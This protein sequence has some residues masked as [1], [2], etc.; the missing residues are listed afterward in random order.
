[1]E[2][3]DFIKNAIINVDTIEEMFADADLTDESTK[4]RYKISRDRVKGG[5]EA[6]QRLGD[7]VN[8]GDPESLAKVMMAGFLKNHRYLQAEMLDGIMI[9]LNMLSELPEELKDPRNEGTLKAI[10]RIVDERI[11]SSNDDVRYIYRSRAERALE[12]KKERV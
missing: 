4:S 7:Y 8:G 3:R 11:V 5:I 9:F 2:Y 10:H 1:M 6:M 12:T